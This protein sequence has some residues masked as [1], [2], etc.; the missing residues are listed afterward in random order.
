MDRLL[1]TMRNTGSARQAG[2]LAPTS[3]SVDGLETVEARNH[4]ISRAPPARH[5]CAGRSENGG[6]LRW[7]VAP[8]EHTSAEN[9]SVQRL[10]RFVRAS[11][12][13]ASWLVQPAEPPDADPHVRSCGGGEWATTPPMPIPAL[14]PYN[15][16]AGPMMFQ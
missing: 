14:A 1:R 7:T 6:Q 16:V 13:H 12:A 9:R 4:K 2:A 10:L 8:C 11:R 15:R 3:I 5:C